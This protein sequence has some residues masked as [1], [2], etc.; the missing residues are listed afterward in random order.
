MSFSGILLI[1]VI[2]LILFGPEDLPKVARTI[3]KMIFEV[4][5][6]TNE[7]TKEFQ[8][9]MGS[10]GDIVNKTL[11]Q[12]ASKTVAQQETPGKQGNSITDEEL[13]SYDDEIP[14]SEKASPAKSE[15]PIILTKP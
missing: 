8:G 14:T 2:A 3:G 11:M 15:G 4:R 7:L 6:V 1:M 10:P 9:S 13:L 5:K 12:T